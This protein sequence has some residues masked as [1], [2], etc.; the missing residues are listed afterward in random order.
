[1]FMTDPTFITASDAAKEKGCSNQNV[2]Q[3]LDRGVLTE[4]RVGNTR[5]IVK[6]DAYEEWV[7]VDPATYT[8]SRSDQQ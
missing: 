8:R 3:A 7:S 1:M 2:Y 6:D 5:L 4:R